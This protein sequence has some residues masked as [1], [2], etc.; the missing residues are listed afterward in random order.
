[1]K[2]FIF[3]LINLLLSISLSTNAQLVNKNK[4]ITMKVNQPVYKVFENK[5]L[6]KSVLPAPFSVDTEV[7]GKVKNY[8]DYDIVISE[9]LT[10][11]DYVNLAGAMLV[12]DRLIRGSVW[13][14]NYYIGPCTYENVINAFEDELITNPCKAE[15]WSMFISSFDMTLD[16]ESAKNRVLKT[17][18]EKFCNGMAYIGTQE[19]LSGEQQ[20]SGIKR[21]MVFRCGDGMEHTVQIYTFG[22]NLKLSVL[23]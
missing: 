19:K 18:I 1:M 23:I 15:E 4:V 5:S 22:K 10:N 21:Y 9:D 17:D 8:I 13:F 14:V 2:K 3:I 12:V 16:E 11:E 7:T 20:G 6:Y